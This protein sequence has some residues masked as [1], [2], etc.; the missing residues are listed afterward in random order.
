MILFPLS[1]A[2]LTD[3]FSAD[4]HTSSLYVY[5]HAIDTFTSY[6]SLDK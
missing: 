1:N 3:M 5:A 4:T 2:L 6:S